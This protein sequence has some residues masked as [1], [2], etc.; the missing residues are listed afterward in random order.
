MQLVNIFSIND[1]FCSYWIIFLEFVIIRGEIVHDKHDQ[2][3][4][5]SGTQIKLE[6]IEDGE[7]GHIIDQVDFR[8]SSNKY[9]CPFEYW[10]DTSRIKTKNKYRLE[11]ILADRILPTRNSTHQKHPTKT[12]STHSTI[13]EINPT[14]NTEIND[15]KIIVSDVQ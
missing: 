5:L 3:Y 7:K 8:C 15:Y 2:V 13:I 4:D 12:K 14:I 10:F 11:A 6:L 9:P 1:G